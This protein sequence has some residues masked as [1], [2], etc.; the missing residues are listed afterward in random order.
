M[1]WIILSLTAAALWG[2]DYALTERALTKVSIP[3]LMILHLVATIMVV[4]I[5]AFIK[6]GIMND[7]N[8][9]MNDKKLALMILIAVLSAAIAGILIYASI[10]AKNA[11]LSGLVEISYPI[12]IIIFS[13]LIFGQNSINK[14]TILGG[15][16]IF[17]G[18]AIIYLRS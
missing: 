10:V 7:F 14:F 2:L 15:A 11:A 16:M 6:G 8:I 5:Y 4:L 17:T 13:Y 3:T 18:V 9:I 1:L 12:F